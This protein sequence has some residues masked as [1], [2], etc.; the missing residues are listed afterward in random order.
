MNRYMVQY[1]AT[2]KGCV[3]IIAE[4][5]DEAWDEAREDLNSSRSE[6]IDHFYCDVIFIDSD[7]EAEI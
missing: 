2:V 7:K 5:E 3:E 6:D 4:S 1:T